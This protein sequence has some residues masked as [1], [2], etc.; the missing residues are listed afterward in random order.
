MLL[1]YAATV[2]PRRSIDDWVQ[3]AYLYGGHL[4]AATDLRSP[5]QQLVDCGLAKDGIWIEV[6]PQLTALVEQ[7]R[8]LALREI[9]QLLLLESPPTWLR[10]AVSEAGVAREYIPENDLRSLRW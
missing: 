1:A 9:A 5:A 3:A 7:E 10:F 8:R 2:A 4:A 6:A